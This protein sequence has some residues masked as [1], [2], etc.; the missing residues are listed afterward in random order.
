M[1]I[2]EDVAVSVLFCKYTYL[3]P[4]NSLSIVTCPPKPY[5][6]KSPVPVPLE[7]APKNVFWSS[8]VPSTALKSKAYNKVFSIGV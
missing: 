1:K 2:P 3:P 5:A 6:S 4:T 7:L 8:L